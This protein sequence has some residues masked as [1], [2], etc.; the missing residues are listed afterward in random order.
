M[1][2]LLAF[3]DSLQAGSYAASRSIAAMFIVLLG[4]VVLQADRVR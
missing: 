3:S 4:L 2:G 1:V